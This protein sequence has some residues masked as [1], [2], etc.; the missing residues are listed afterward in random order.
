MNI[1]SSGWLQRMV[2]K[3]GNT[4]ARRIQVLFQILQDWSDVP[5]FR[6][7]LHDVMSDKTGQRALKAYLLQLVEASKV[8]HSD[9]VASQVHMILLGALNEELRQPGSQALEHAG[10]AAVLLI[11]AQLPARKVSYGRMAI[12]ASVMLMAGVLALLYTG[13]QPE[14][15]SMHPQTIAAISAAPSPE[16]VAA[17]YRMHEKMQAANCSYP[18]ALMMAPEQR[19]PFLENVVDGNIGKMQPEALIMVSQL[20][21]KVDCYYP[22]AAML[23]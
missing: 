7:Q 6:Q 1:F 5:G 21:Q 11:N 10:Q 18:Q 4:P 2:D 12:A 15:I 22:P 8:T 20:Y 23:L 13:Q 9:L 19:A 3:A 14:Q 16:S 17:L